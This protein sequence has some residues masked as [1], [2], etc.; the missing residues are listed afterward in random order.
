MKQRKD[1]KIVLIIIGIILI[2]SA[3]RSIYFTYKE[4]KVYKEKGY[5]TTKTFCIEENSYTKNSNR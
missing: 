4:D 2:F 3:I 1:L 5:K